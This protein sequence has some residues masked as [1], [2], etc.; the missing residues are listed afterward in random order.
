MTL[1]EKRKWFVDEFLNSMFDQWIAE[2]KQTGDV[3]N[4]VDVVPEFTFDS[5]SPV[6]SITKG[7]SP[8]ADPMGPYREFMKMQDK[9][10]AQRMM[11]DFMMLIDSPADEPV[12]ATDP[13]GAAP[14]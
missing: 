2:A 5:E 11:L 13:H 7:T 14:S 12:I 3:P 1:E 6:I 8:L 4:D 9:W 10:M